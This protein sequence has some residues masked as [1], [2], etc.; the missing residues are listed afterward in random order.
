[1]PI[2]GENVTLQTTEDS[3]SK[4]KLETR[5]E[6]LPLSRFPPPSHPPPPPLNSLALSLSLSFSN[7]S[8]PFC[9]N[10][11]KNFY[12]VLSVPRG[13]NDGAARQAIAKFP[14]PATAL[15]LSA[16]PRGVRVAAAGS[17]PPFPQSG[18]RR[19][20]AGR[21]SPGSPAAARFPTG[22]PSTGRAGRA[23]CLAARAWVRE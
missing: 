19:W 11:S 13:A 10:N 22:G 20:G 14:R 8:P 5:S 23:S 17:G 16:W 1:M 6:S 9:F 3:R 7:P 18:R 4:R 2:G 12:D 15:P 21:R